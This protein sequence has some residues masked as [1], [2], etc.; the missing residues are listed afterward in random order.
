MLQAALIS[1]W[2]YI[3]PPRVSAASAIVLVR[4]LINA[5]PPDLSDAERNALRTMRERA[6]AVQEIEKTRERLRPE[7]L[8]DED[9]LFDGYWGAL[10]DQIFSWLRVAGTPQYT[11][12]ERLQKALF[13]TGLDFITLSYETQWYESAKRLE[14]IVEE[15]LEDLINQLVHPT[16]L[17]LVREAHQSL[18]EGL[19]VGETAIEEPDSEA[20]RKALRAVSLSVSD[21]ARILSGSVDTS[22]PVST[23][24]FLSAMAPLD[25]HRAAYP[26]T[27]ASRT[28]TDQ[29]PASPTPDTPAPEPAVDPDEP[30]P[31]APLPIV[32]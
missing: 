19:G 18:G 10:K 29:P 5:A 11:I 16:L 28:P 24:R 31:E 15:N 8:K 9:R 12:A 22:D 6:V 17:P 13:L 1:F 2:L 7:N 30:G 21:Y 20:L 25:K 26:T 3:T 4:R 27:P 14:R 32:E 23:A